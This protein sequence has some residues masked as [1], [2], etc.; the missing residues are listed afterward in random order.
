M[1]PPPAPEGNIHITFIPVGSADDGE[2]PIGIGNMRWRD[3][4]W[5]AQMQMSAPFGS[6]RQVLHWAYMVQCKPDDLEWERLP[7]TNQSLP[8]FMQAAGFTIAD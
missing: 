6:D 8:D 3:G 1:V 5:T 2:G 7:G 4:S